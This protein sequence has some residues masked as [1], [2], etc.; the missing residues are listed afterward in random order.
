MPE[1]TSSELERENAYL[2]LRLAQLASDLVDLK[3]ENGRL[4]EER[5][6]LHAR[7][8]ARAP[9]PLGGGQ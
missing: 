2:K 6:R 8:A 1:R 7:R 5:E 3:A 9:N 4:Q